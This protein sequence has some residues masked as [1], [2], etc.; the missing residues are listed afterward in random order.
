MLLTKRADQRAHPLDLSGIQTGGRL[1]QD[2]Q[3]RLTQKRQGE[4]YTL[5]IP[6]G[7][8]ML[9]LVEDVAKLAALNDR[10]DRAR[11]DPFNRRN[12]PQIFVH[13]KLWIQRR[14]LWEKADASAR[15]KRLL[16]G[17]EPID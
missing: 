11:V 5:S 8:L 14:R 2:Q 1:I 7:E 4:P 3:W 15:F 13:T 17:I 6:L 9:Q 16:K 10:S 12:E